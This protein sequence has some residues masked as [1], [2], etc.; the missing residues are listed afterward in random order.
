MARFRALVVTIDTPVSGIRERD[1]RNGMKE[2]ISG[3]WH[4]KSVHLPQVLSRPGWLASFL[5][6][7][8]LPALPN[9]VV[10][11]KGPL[12]LVDI[13]AALAAAAVTWSDLRWIRELWSGPDFCFQSRWP[14]A[15]LC[16]GSPARLAGGGQR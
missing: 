2:L 12:P 7:G 6:D 16:R 8:G 15:R 4:Q 1:Y 13:N 5:Y 14:P 3:G 9:V 11:G 10:P